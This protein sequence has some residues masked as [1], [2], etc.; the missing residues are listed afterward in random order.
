MIQTQTQTHTI[1]TPRLAK[2]Q[3]TTQN[4]SPK[5]DDSIGSL[6]RREGQ[7]QR[8]GYALI[9]PFFIFFLRVKSINAEACPTK[10]AN[11]IPTG[12]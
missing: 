8:Q 1:V 5:V 9:T 2:L 6:R 4:E 10:A 3:Q 12:F 11:I 7:H